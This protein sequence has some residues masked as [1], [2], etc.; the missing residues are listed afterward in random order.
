MDTKNV[1]NKVEDQI[2][3]F[4]AEH[5]GELPLYL[6]MASEDADTLANE[7]RKRQGYDEQTLVT[8]YNGTK[9]VKHY[10]MTTGEVRASNEMP[11]TSS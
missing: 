5:K 7:V 2:R 3:R 8:E 10:S 11:E 9:I 6:I 1:L 4:Q